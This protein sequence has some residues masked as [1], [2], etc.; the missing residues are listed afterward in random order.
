MAVA[1]ADLK[2]FRSVVTDDTA[3]N[4]GRLS[5]SQIQ[6]GVVEALFPDADEAEQA[7]GSQKHRKLFV[8]NHANPSEVAY[9]ARVFLENYTPASDENIFFAASQTDTQA[10]ITGAEDKFG[11]GQLDADVS[12]GAS[13]I[14]VSVHDWANLPIFRNGVLLRISDKADIDA[15]G[16]TEFIYVH[17]STAISAAA[18]VVT[19]PLATNLVGSYLAANTR[20]ASVLDHGVLETTIDNWVETS[21]L[22]TYDEGTYPVAGDN[23]GTIE[24]IWTFTWSDGSNFTVSGDTIGSVG[25][26]T[27]GADFSPNNPDY[28]APYFTLEQEG[29]AGTWANGDTLVFHTHPANIP[30]WM[31]RDIPAGTTPQSGNKSVLVLKTG[32]A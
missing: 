13:S 1:N 31:L 20:V 15:P 12:A 26:G 28:S 32:S 23:L 9:G 16:N 24:Q 4:G 6:S 2:L 22:G 17:A 18:N 25:S 11:V 29:F 3:A 19:I 14:D 30:L 5:T 27:I 10:G 8:A 7:A 21:T